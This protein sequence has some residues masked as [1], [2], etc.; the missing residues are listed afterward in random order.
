MQNANVNDYLYTWN[1]QPPAHVDR[2]MIDDE[3]LRDGLQGAFAPRIPLEQQMEILRLTDA[4]GV[5]YSMIGFPSNAVEQLDD[6]RRL[7]DF[8]AR[9]KLRTIPTLLARMHVTDVEPLVALRSECSAAFLVDLFIGTSPL[10]RRVEGWTL[11]TI[12]DCVR[13][14]C[15][16]LVKAGVRIG[17]SFEDSSRTPPAELIALIELGIDV[18]MERLTICDTVGD[19]LPEGA[20]RIVELSREVLDKRSSPC[21]LSWHG[22][23]DKGCAV[24]NSIAAVEAGADGVSG[25]FL[26]LGER[27]GNAP[28][29]QVIAYLHQA[30]SR[31]FRV[32]LLPRLAARISEITGHAIAA[33]AP[34]VGMQAFA[35]TAGVHSAALLKAR[36]LGREFEDYVYS[37]VPASA[38]GRSQAVLL[39][40]TSGLANARN[41]LELH[42]FA[43]NEALA[44]RLLAHAKKLARWMSPEE[45]GLYIEQ[46]PA[47]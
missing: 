34:V 38:F 43:P 26:G 41:A 23:N 42:G 40:P 25:T 33:T 24:A 17:I 32:D 22:H 4:I 8:V 19:S 35:T 37:G 16:R 2:V 7:I 18:G 5:T 36:K 12:F 20:R 15:E 31:R 27:T 45:I 1:P 14:A 39:G 9:E 11:Q 29:E 46:R 13:P 47:L 28:L 10:R 6:C 21:A 30:G 3:T 44:T